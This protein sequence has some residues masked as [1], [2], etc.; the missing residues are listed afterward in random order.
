L[1]C[2]RK[3]EKLRK[4]LKASQKEVQ[5]LQSEF[6]VERDDFL[7]T[8]RGAERELKLFTAIAKRYRTP[9]LQLFFGLRWSAWIS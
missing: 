7:E 5:D 1:L 6:Q 9:H 4:K 8:I 2:R 3:L